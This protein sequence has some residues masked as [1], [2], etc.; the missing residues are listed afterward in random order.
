MRPSAQLFLWKWVLFA[1][2]WKMISISKAEHLPSFWFRGPGELGNGLLLTFLRIKQ[3]YRKWQFLIPGSKLKKKKTAR[4]VNRDLTKLRRQGLR[5]GGGGRRTQQIF[6]RGGSSRGSTS[7]PFIYHFS[8]KRYPF[9][10]PSLTNGAPFTYSRLSPWGHF[11]VTDI[12]LMQTRA[13]PLTKR[14]KKWLK[15]TPWLGNEDSH[16]PAPKRDISLVFF[17]FSLSADTW[18]RQKSWLT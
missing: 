16:F 12:P 17:F 1:W 13:G 9:R 4:A 6:V 15:Q 11:A 18:V 2:E 5:K 7:Y 10:I 8:R 14:I 3:N